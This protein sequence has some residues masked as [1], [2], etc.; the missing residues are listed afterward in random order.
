MSNLEA[1]SETESNDL[2]HVQLPTGEVRMWSLDQLD[3]AFQAEL[4]DERTHVLQDGTTDWVKLGE[5]LGLDSAPASEAPSAQLPASA[6]SYTPSYATG[7][8]ASYD[9][10]SVGAVSVTP[11]P[12]SVAPNSAALYSVR[13]VVADIP[14]DLDLD[15]VALRPRKKGLFVGLAAAALVLGIVGFAATRLGGSPA[16]APAVSAVSPTLPQP[17]PE[18]VTVAPQAPPPPLV[19]PA[20][21]DPA[22]ATTTNSRLTPSQRKALADADKNRDSARKAR[23]S[24][25][26]RAP[27]TTSKP[28]FHKGGNKY[29]PLNSSI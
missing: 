14:D 13:P 28:V 21:A 25:P 15:S 11:G 2:W 17:V 29:D 12:V 10:P 19:A 3:A 8:P 5:L 6:P 22:P 24:A 26:A 7:A 20:A 23:A 4:I 27:R 1:A 16:S 18:A 9:P